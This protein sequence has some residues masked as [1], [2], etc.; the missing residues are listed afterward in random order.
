MKKFLDVE[1][2][3]MIN[4]STKKP[5]YQSGR[6]TIIVAM[7]STGGIGKNGK[8][9]WN[10][11]EDLRW[12]KKITTGHI[13]VFGR[14]TWE[15]IPKNQ[16]PLKSRYNIVVSNTK[17]KIELESEIDGKI[18][19]VH[20]HLSVSNYVKLTQECVNNEIMICGGAQIYK[21]FLYNKLVDRML[22]TV[23]DKDYKCDK[24]FPLVYPYVGWKQEYKES[25]YPT[26]DTTGSY[27]FSKRVIEEK[28][29]YYRVE[30][31][32]GG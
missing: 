1:F 15:S 28:E 31:L 21:W 29:D 20:N 13:V 27:I 16:R 17:S 10:C 19:I 32:K 4:S 2:K 11:P 6:I 12:F 5:L 9:P 8:L 30:C 23:F 7:D 22:V 18:D 14:K 26:R 3:P 24:F 25:I